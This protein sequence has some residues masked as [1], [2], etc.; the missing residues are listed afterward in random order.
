MATVYQAQDLKHHRHVAI[1]DGD[2]LLSIEFLVWAF[3]SFGALPR[4]GLLRGPASAD[5]PLDAGDHHRRIDPEIRGR[6]ARIGNVVIPKLEYEARTARSVLPPPN[7]KEK[8]EVEHAIDL[9]NIERRP[10]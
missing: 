9:R 8:L 5:H 2:Q 1:T 4:A 3:G 6:R 7:A 10:K